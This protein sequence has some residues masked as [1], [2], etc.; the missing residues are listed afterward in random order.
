MFAANAFTLLGLR[1]LY[2]LVT[3]LLDRLVYLSM[4]LSVILAFIAA[5]CCCI[6]GTCRTAASPRSKQEPRLS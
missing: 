1:A 2:F 4:G 3:G 5:N 6:S